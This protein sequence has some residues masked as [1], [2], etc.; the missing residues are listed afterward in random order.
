MTINKIIK[1]GFIGCGSVTETKSGPPY[2][3]TNGFEIAAVMRR[4]ENLAKDYAKRHNIPKYY[5]DADALI[6]NKDIDAIYIATPPDTHKLYA[7]KVAKANK[8]CCIEKPITP[9]YTEALEIHKAFKDKQVP[10]FV[11]Y[12][13]RSLPRFEKIKEWLSE[14]H[15]GNVR[16]INWC[17][18]KP[19]NK[20]DLS[21]TYN[22][23]TD[24]NIAPAGYFDDLASHG[25]DLFTFLL[26][27]IKDAKGIS[28]NQQN[29]YNAKDAITACWIHEN[30]ITGSGNWNFGA[31]EHE[32]RVKISGSRGTIEF[33]VFHENP[34]ILTSEYK[35][36][37]LT[38][39][40]PKHIQLHHVE[41][42]K[43]V[44]IGNKQ[45]H[46]STGSTALHTSWVMDKIL[47]KI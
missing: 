25:L 32:D 45:T 21:K 34:L 39:E 4:N 6:N 27:D 26:G 37:E 9:H 18:N 23:R 35:N 14:K 42:M 41:N 31:N 13:R 44:L 19:V 47:E 2:T 12:Y 11:A 1:W 46:P 10:L 30:G 36:E 38:I 22:W 17:M 43:K 15:I 16:H 5:T 20:T 3:L 24:V 28:T 40:N 8:P 7:L 29:L 33:S